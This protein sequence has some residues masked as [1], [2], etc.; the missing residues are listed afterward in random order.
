[1]EPLC[2]HLARGAACQLEGGAI[3]ALC[4]PPEQYVQ[5]AAAQMPPLLLHA[6][7]AVRHRLL[8]CGVVQL[9]DEATC[10]S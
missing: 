6:E 10:K 8:V 3:S 5:D 4:I 7:N 9:P 2:F 1:M